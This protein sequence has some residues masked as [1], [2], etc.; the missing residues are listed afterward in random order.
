MKIKSKYNGQPHVDYSL[1]QKIKNDNTNINICEIRS[2]L[3]SMN[4]FR[5]DIYLIES[6]NLLKEAKIISDKKVLNWK[7]MINELKKVKIKTYDLE[8]IDIKEKLL[9]KRLKIITNH[10]K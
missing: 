5:N 10:K 1:I 7:A 2:T 8:P 4:F 6:L 3:N 9:Q